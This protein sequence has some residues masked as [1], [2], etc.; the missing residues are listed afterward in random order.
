MKIKTYIEN[1]I[2]INQVTPLEQ[3]MASIELKENRKNIC[4]SCIDYN[5]DN[6]CNSC[7][8]I[9]DTLMTFITSECPINKW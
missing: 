7:G 3:D 8:C 2:T 9:V 4:L 1:G 6:T 5:N